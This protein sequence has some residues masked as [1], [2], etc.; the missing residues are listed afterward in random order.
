MAVSSEQKEIIK[1]QIRETLSQELEIQ[2]I[3]LFGSFVHSNS[4]N[5]I[6][7]AIFQNSDEKYL[8]LSLKY[9]KLVRDISKIIPVDIIPLKTA[10]KGYFVNEIESGEVIYE[11]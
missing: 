1:G 2:K 10:S 7:I 3:V 6:D 4:P 8:S 11:R 5:D 9:R